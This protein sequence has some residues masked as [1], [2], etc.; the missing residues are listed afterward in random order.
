M[1]KLEKVDVT[2]LQKL[3]GHT[4]IDTTMI[5]LNMSDEAAREKSKQ[6]TEF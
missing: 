3:L 6:F 1:D 2:T 5:Y 4:E